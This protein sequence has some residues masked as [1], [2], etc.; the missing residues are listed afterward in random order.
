MWITLL[1]MAL[2]SAEP[3]RL[4][5]TVL[6]LNRPRPQLQLLAFLWWVVV[7]TTVGF[8]GAVHFPA[9]V[10]WIGAVTFRGSVASGWRHCSSPRTGMRGSGSSWSA[11]LD[12]VTGV[13][14]RR[15]G[16]SLWWHWLPGCNRPA[17]GRFLAALAVIVASARPGGHAGHPVDARRHRLA[18]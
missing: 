6:M 5:M 7:G 13:F 16:G 14:V 3:F 12:K 2:P 4:G 1:V 17:L 18:R 10:D 8:R 15:N 9:R 11:Q